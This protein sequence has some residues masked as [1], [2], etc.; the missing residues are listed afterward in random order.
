MM[1]VFAGLEIAGGIIFFIWCM[2]IHKRSP[3]KQ[4]LIAAWILST[5]IVLSGAI[6]VHNV[7]RGN[8][9]EWEIHEDGSRRPI[10]KINSV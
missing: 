2:K 9:M 3:N 10:K 7:Y 1:Y 5:G 8:N 6:T 4:W